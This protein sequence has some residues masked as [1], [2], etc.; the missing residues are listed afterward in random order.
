MN[1]VY[2]FW[3]KPYLANGKKVHGEVSAKM[4]ALC[5]ILSVHYAKR[6]FDKVKLVTDTEGYKA[7]V[8]LDLP[9]DSVSLELDDIPDSVLP[10]MWAYGK[11]IAYEV[12]KEPFVHIDYDA[13]LFKKPCK[14]FYEADIIVQ[15]KEYFHLENHFYYSS[16][17]KEVKNWDFESKYYYNKAPYAY[18]CGTFGGNDLEFIKK[19]VGEAKKLALYPNK[20]Q[21][22]KLGSIER[23]LFPIAFEQHILGSIC[24]EEKET[25]QIFETARDD[26]RIDELGYFHLMGG[27]KNPLFLKQLEMKA[28]KECSKEYMAWVHKTMMKN[29]ENYLSLNNYEI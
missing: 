5:W 10:E 26:K 18:N 3:S 4:F 29:P 1:A 27:K 9:F 23:R 14:Q 13:F 25:N 15:H 16:I 17:R 21:L 8:E 2:S 11:L 7:L 20:D 22:N 19:Y 28:L 12:Q 24:Y 6:Y